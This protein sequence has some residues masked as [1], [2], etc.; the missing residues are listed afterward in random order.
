VDDVFGYL[1]WL[2]CRGPVLVSR[3]DIYN[4]GQAVF[5]DPSLFVGLHTPSPSWV[6]H[7]TLKMVAERGQRVVDIGSHKDYSAAALLSETTDPNSLWVENDKLQTLVVT[8]TDPLMMRLETAYKESQIKNVFEVVVRTVD[9]PALSSWIR[10][11]LFSRFLGLGVGPEYRLVFVLPRFGS[12]L[13][14]LQDLVERVVP[15][16]NRE[17]IVM[18]VKRT[19]QL[20]EMVGK[21][22]LNK[23]KRSYRWFFTPIKLGSGKRPSNAV[24]LAALNR[25]RQS[26]YIGLRILRYHTVIPEHMYV[27]LRDMFLRQRSQLKKLCKLYDE[28]AALE[29]TMFTKERARIENMKRAALGEK[30]L[31]SGP[32]LKRLRELF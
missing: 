29:H 15:E 6:A 1:V 21:A 23:M 13:E 22:L 17:L 18:G 26:R 9:G 30:Q 12:E 7:R 25:L 8:A 16:R 14:R 4:A 10:T 19:E 2:E 24:L 32:V 20:S 3:D 11:V 5:G 31:P 28:R 27:E